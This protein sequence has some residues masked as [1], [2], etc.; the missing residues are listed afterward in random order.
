[1]D[2]RVELR[3]PQVRDLA[4]RGD[5]G[6]LQRVLGEPGSRRI[7]KATAYSRSLT[8]CTRCANASRSPVPGPLDEARSTSASEWPR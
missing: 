4:P 7:R 2:P 5:E 8:W 6:V 3:V 1:M